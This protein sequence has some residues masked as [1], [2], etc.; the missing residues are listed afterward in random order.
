MKKQL[1][2]LFLALLPVLALAAP[3]A[4]AE[5]PTTQNRVAQLQRQMQDASRRLA[6]IKRQLAELQAQLPDPSSFRWRDGSA[7]RLPKDAYVASSIHGYSGYLC[8][9]S[10]LAADHVNQ[11]YTANP[12]AVIDPGVLTRNGCLITYAGE[13]HLIGRYKVLAGSAAGSWEAVGSG[14]MPGS[15]GS[16]GSQDTPD[17]HGGQAVVGGREGGKDVYICRVLIQDPYRDQYLLGKSVDRT[18]YIAAGAAEINWPDSNYEILLAPDLSTSAAI[19]VPAVPAGVTPLTL[20]GPV[21][22]H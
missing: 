8:Q 6:S 11:N 7:G 21:R 5:F 1:A 16:G 17:S 13:S 12:T 2:G 18:C 22:L 3:T 20:S 19:P 9:A 4:A 10:Y 15:H 14:R